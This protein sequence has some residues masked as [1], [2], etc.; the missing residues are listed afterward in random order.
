MSPVEP[1]EQHSDRRRNIFFVIAVLAAAFLVLTV[2]SVEKFKNYLKIQGGELRYE[3]SYGDDESDD[4]V[5]IEEDDVDVV[6]DVVNTGQLVI[7]GYI[8]YGGVSAPN[9]NETWLSNEM[10][11]WWDMNPEGLCTSLAPYASKEDIAPY[12]GYPTGASLQQK[13]VQA[14]LFDYLGVNEDVR[15]YASAAL[16]SE[17]SEDAFVMGVCEGPNTGV[18]LKTMEADG[19]I[20]VVYSM[21]VDDAGMFRIIPYQPVAGLMD[22]YE[23]IPDTGRGYALI[24]TGYGDAGFI[25]WKYY[26]LN[27]EFMTTELIE[28][29]AGGPE[30]DGMGNYIENSWSLE[31]ELEYSL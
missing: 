15:K 26:K 3:Y 12:Y 18:F 30:L 25:S 5:V 28:S 14:A 20:A 24:S 10:S 17:V 6:D 29:C 19:R 7:P 22:G 8:A 31:C 16:L 27:A 11:T 13:D 1:S 21:F 4:D 23:F 9:I 2:I